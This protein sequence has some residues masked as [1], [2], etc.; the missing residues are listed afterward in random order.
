MKRV[1]K[2]L[3]RLVRRILKRTT[4]SHRFGFALGRVSA[5]FKAVRLSADMSVEEWTRNS[6]AFWRAERYYQALRKLGAK[7]GYWKYQ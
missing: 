6:A 4:R 5:Q 7:W 1:L 3:A 2:S